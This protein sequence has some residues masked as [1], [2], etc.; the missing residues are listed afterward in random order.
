MGKSILKLTVILL[1]LAGVFL[2]C[3]KKEKGCIS[4]ENKEVIK[5]LKDEPAYIRKGCF[6]H[7][8]RIDTFYF[9]L[10]NRYPEFFAEVGLFPCGE[11]PELFRKEG[12]SVNISGNVTNCIETGGCIE[13]NIKLPYIHLFELESITI[14]NKK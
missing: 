9:E 11:I 1:I 3:E 8:G 12:L 7:V 4:C 10:V 2:N 5:T 13:P 14:N 6:E